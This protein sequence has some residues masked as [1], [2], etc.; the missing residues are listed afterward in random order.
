MTSLTNRQVVLRRRPEGLL[1]DGD[2]ELITEPA[3]ELAE[4]E[5]LVRK[6]IHLPRNPLY[7]ATLLGF[8]WYQHAV[9]SGYGMLD[10]F[11]LG[12]KNAAQVLQPTREAKRRE[13]FL[14]HM[15]IGPDAAL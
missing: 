4:G 10:D 13:T 14:D 6:L 7:D 3:P 15:D 2:T 5:A 1:R 11:L 8:L 12:L 9:V